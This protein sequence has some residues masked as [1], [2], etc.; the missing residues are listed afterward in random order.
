MQNSGSELYSRRTKNGYS[1]E[2]S[3]LIIES[4]NW[5]GLKVNDDIVYQSQNIKD[6]IFIRNMFFVY[7]KRGATGERVSENM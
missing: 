7:K 5:L 4:L 1:K 6:H 3:K 2:S